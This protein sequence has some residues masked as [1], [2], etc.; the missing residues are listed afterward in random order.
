MKTLFIS[1]L[2]F[3]LPSEERP[4]AIVGTWKNSTG[5][6]HV[7]I[8][9][10]NGKFHG[11]ITWLKDATDASGKPKTDIK[12]NDPD[13]TKKPQIGTLML[14]DFEYRKGEWTNGR[15]YNPSDGKEYKGHIKL[16]PDRTLNVR[17][18]VGISI[19]GKSDTWTRVK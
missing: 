6:G 8:F 13:Q 3:F 1:L 4:D 2:L 10:Q 12:N 11:K 17:G 14:K 9:R 15:I 5:K 16:N 18:Y 7:Q 19:L